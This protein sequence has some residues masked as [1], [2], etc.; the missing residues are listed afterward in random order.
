[1]KESQI[2]SAVQDCLNGKKESFGHIVEV[3]QNPLFRF[4]FHLLGSTEDARDALSE[5]FMKTFSSLARYDQNQP[6]SGWI[7][8]IAYNH[9]MDHLRKRKREKAFLQSQRSLSRSRSSFLPRT[10][11]HDLKNLEMERMTR[12]LKKLPARY[13]SSLL[14]RYHLDLPYADIARI[15]NEPI[16]TVRILIFR[17]KKELRKIMTQERW[18]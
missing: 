5:V 12:A 9:C 4:C 2:I 11:A 10:E 8:R 1:M 18:K 6:F 14:L 13:L 16:S 17:G 7:Y 3:F 15:M